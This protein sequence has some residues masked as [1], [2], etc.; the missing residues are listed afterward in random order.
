MADSVLKKL[1]NFLWN[2][3]VFK[4]LSLAQLISVEVS[5][6]SDHLF[7][8]L[9]PFFHFIRKYDIVELVTRMLTVPF[10][11]HP[12]ADIETSW[13]SVEEV[14]MSIDSCIYPRLIPFGILQTP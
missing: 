10:D 12:H 6:A 9:L 4:D 5:F 1:V 11:P 14:V 13:P 8:R 3:F 2:L 7:P